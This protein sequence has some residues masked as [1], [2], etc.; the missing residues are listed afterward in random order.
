MIFLL[1]TLSC[2]TVYAKGAKAEIWSYDLGERIE[3]RSIS[4]GNENSK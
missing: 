4:V 2:G 1:I 3:H